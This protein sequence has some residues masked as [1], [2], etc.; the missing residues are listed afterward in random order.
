M[1]FVMAT[2]IELAGV[3]VLRQSLENQVDK[4]LDQSSE[5]VTLNQQNNMKKRIYR[6]TRK[7]DL[8][9]AFLYSLCYTLFN[10]WHWIHYLAI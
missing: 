9:C 2:L 7:I 6:L 8:A 10:M 3:L 1:V 4:R 5:T